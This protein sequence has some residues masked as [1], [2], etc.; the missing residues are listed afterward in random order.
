MFISGNDIANAL[1]RQTEML[2]EAAR[3]RQFASLHNKATPLHRSVA[4]ALGK[5]FLWIGTRLLSYGRVERPAALTVQQ[6]IQ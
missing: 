5:A 2:A 4:G 1:D 6:N 3:E